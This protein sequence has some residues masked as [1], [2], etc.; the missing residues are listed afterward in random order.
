MFD[1]NYPAKETGFRME[2][3]TANSHSMTADEISRDLKQA[4]TGDQEKAHVFYKKLLTDSLITR[5]YDI[6][7]VDVDE[8]LII[9]PH[10]KDCRY[11]K[12][13]QTIIVRI[14]PE[15]SKLYIF[16]KDNKMWREDFYLASE[17]VYGKLHLEEIHFN[18]EY[19]TGY[20]WNHEIGRSL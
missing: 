7:K 13:C 16:D 5:G 18:D 2:K 8:S 10:K 15:V 20:P 12:Y 3:Q 17:Y 19:P 1:N 14:Y 4:V 11:F 9:G 6:S